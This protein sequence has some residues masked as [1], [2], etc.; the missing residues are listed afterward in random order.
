MINTTLDTQT[1][2]VA[3][4][5]TRRQLI[6]LENPDARDRD[7]LHGGDV[8]KR[9]VEMVNVGKQRLQMVTALHVNLDDWP[10]WD[11]SVGFMEGGK[12]DFFVHQRAWTDEMWQTAEKALRELISMPYEVSGLRS[13]W[14]TK[15]RPSEW[16]ILFKVT[17]LERDTITVALAGG[18][19][20]K[21]RIMTD[22]KERT[23]K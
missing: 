11:A 17:P 9:E 18:L 2:P 12:S 1:A 3:R 7:E 8:F 14:K 6:A 10:E 15:A 20:K 21:V 22:P 19:V 13:A 16:H 23:R 4:Q 5:Y